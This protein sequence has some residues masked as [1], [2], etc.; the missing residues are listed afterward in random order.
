[1]TPAS[2]SQV[3]S[4]RYLDMESPRLAIETVKLCCLVR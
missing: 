3:G 1:M 2:F 4:G